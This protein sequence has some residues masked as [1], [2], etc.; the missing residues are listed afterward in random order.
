MINQCKKENTWINNAASFV[1]IYL[2]TQYSCIMHTDI[3]NVSTKTANATLCEIRLILKR[4]VGNTIERTCDNQ[5]QVNTTQS[6]PQK[7]WEQAVLKA[8]RRGGVYELLCM[9]SVDLW[10]CGLRMTLRRTQGREGIEWPSNTC[11]TE[12]GRHCIVGSYDRY[13]CLMHYSGRRAQVEKCIPPSRKLALLGLC[14]LHSVHFD[15]HC[16]TWCIRM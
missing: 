5:S 3:D 14:T 15:W 12:L 2:R 11:V 1:V 6:F 9:F 8:L 7:A 16:R 10:V 4:T 13:H